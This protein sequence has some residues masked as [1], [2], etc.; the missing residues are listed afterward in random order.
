LGCHPEGEPWGDPADWQRALDLQAEL[1]AIC[2][3]GRM[4]RHGEPL[5][6]AADGS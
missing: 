1:L 2:P 4:G 3:P 5:G 6:P